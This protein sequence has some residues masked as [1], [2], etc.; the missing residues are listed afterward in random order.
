MFT[1]PEKIEESVSGITHI[2]KLK[3]VSWIMRISKIGN[4]RN[5][6]SKEPL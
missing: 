4:T 5:I 1:K 6:S 3:K 2:R